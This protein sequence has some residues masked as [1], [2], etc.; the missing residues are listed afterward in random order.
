M[1]SCTN[2]NLTRSIAGTGYQVTARFDVT[3]SI[4][5]SATSYVYKVTKLTLMNASPAM[6]LYYKMWR[7]DGTVYE[8]SV[9]A[10]TTSNKDL[11]NSSW[12]LSVTKT[13]SSATKAHNWYIQFYSNSDRTTK[14]GSKL[15]FG[16]TLNVD[17]KTSYAIT[18]SG[19]GSTSGSVS[20]QTKWYGEALTLRANGYSRTNYAFTGWNTAANGSGTPY[21]ASSTMA[22]GMNAK[23]TLYA[24]WSQVYSS[25]QLVI[26]NSYR[27]DASGNPDDEGKYAA[28]ECT[29]KLWKTANPNEVDYDD[30]LDE[31]MF[32][33]TVSRQQEATP[34]SDVVQY[35]DKAASPASNQF[36]STLSE[37]GNWLEGT[38][39][40]VVNADLKT[41]SAYP[42]TVTVYDTQGGGS[43]L[44]DGCGTKAATIGTAFYT[45]DVLAGGHG[46]CFGGVAKEDGFRVEMEPA[47]IDGVT[48]AD[49]GWQA[50]TVTGDF[51]A[52]S[53][54]AAPRY[55]KVNGLVEVRGAVKPTSSI[56]IN[57]TTRTFATLPTG[58]RPSTYGLE[59]LSQAS[60]RKMWL[61]TINT[62]GELKASRLR[63]TNSSS[64]VTASTS[65]W[66][67]FHATFFAD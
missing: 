67:V 19:N 21:A 12:D 57:A 49:S 43:G 38:C 32:Y 55:R 2:E 52:Y 50:L 31:Y 61:F 34:R 3:V 16:V 39:K 18:Y 59:T 25:P 60:D 44:S 54:E 22:A 24:Q 40:F 30:S 65:E 26:D 48:I 8:S 1:S 29:F 14:V 63:D 15:S 36:P 33:C 56:T 53:T 42:V 64:Y 10:S 6:R 23:A 11:T 58:Y 62:S 66:L 7:P 20:S 5:E 47:V 51:A 17:A 35:A 28:A 13:H 41:D 46:I 37:S 4:F 27:C 9:A 45:M